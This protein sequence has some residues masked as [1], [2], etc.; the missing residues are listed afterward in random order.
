VKRF[1]STFVEFSC[2]FSI[3]SHLRFWLGTTLQEL[4]SLTICSA[5]TRYTLK[6][7]DCFRGRIIQPSLLR[8]N[9]VT[10]YSFT[11]ASIDQGEGDISIA[12][13]LRGAG[14]VDQAYKDELLHRW[15]DRVKIALQGRGGR[16]VE[17][18]G[19][20]ENGMRR[21]KVVYEEEM[22]GWFLL[23]DGKEERFVL[24]KREY[25]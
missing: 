14:L 9:G 1:G 4:G 23:R 5:T 25:R 11:L 21:V 24:R 7:N 6:A 19:I 2:S 3:Y 20:G 8:K 22:L 17:L 18:Q 13:E 15:S 16:C 10:S 12:I